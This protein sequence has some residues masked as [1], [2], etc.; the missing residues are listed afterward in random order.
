MPSENDNHEPDENEMEWEE[1][2]RQAIASAAETI[3]LDEVR[4]VVYMDTGEDHRFNRFSEEFASTE[5]VYQKLV[6]IGE[7]EWVANVPFDGGEAV[8]EADVEDM[9][10]DALESHELD[11]FFESVARPSDGEEL[12]TGRILTPPGAGLIISTE[13]AEINEELIRYLAR[14]PEKMREMS[15]HKF[16][17]LVA[18]LFRDKGY[19]VELTPRT[20]DG[21]FDIRAYRRSDIG[22][23]LGLIDCKRYALTNKVSVEVV[24][25]LYGVTE[26]ERASIGIIATTSYFTSDA[27]SFQAQNK[28]RV[29]LADFDNVKDWLASYKRKV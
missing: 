9:V 26:S 21:G 24:R 2:A 3:E 19:D 18:E 5:D 1:S 23:F 14:H 11:Q 22:T 28:F 10:V 7:H 13:V 27:K 15:P 17:E 25:G 16:E 12:A 8:F 20:R 4:G 6:E 29:H